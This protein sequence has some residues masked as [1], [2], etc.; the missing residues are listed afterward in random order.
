MPELD[1]CEICGALLDE[2]DM[3]CA[4]CGTEAPHRDG[5][6][7]ERAKSTV[8]THN[9]EC[10]GCGASMSYDASAGA[11]R[12][13]FCG[14]EKLEERKDAKVLAPNRVVPFRYRQNDA[15]LQ[16]RAWLGKGF[17]R[18][19]DLQ[20]RAA[21][22]KMTPVYVPYWVF[23]ARTHT[24]WTADTSQTP[25]GARG[26]WFPLSGEH[27]GE[28]RGL[29]IGASGAL[30]PHETNAICPFDLAAGQPPAEVSLENITCE[31]FSLAR[32]YARPLARQGLES[33]EAQ[34][35]DAQYVPGRSRNVKVNVK[36]E[37]LSSEPV[38]LPVWIMAYRYQEKVYRFL[39]NGQTGKSTG[40]A[41]FSYQKLAMVIAIAVAVGLMLLVLLCGLAAVA[42][43]A[44]RQDLHGVGLRLLNTEDAEQGSPKHEYLVTLQPSEVKPF[45][46]REKRL[47]QTVSCMHASFG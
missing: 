41:P 35:V 12:C 10:G 30:T 22:V 36:I 5:Q 4:N 47:L 1:R 14:S 21:I 31:Q 28:Y 40:Q 18:P 29:L 15:E 19:S 42:G 32:K 8:A 26:D 6:P 7:H 38:L 45:S 46:Q 16:L 43:G 9:F 27:R 37:N 24:Y 11:L 39:V 2:E 44:E 34:A 13:P 33:Q 17:W 20:Q 25:A 23:E 3:F